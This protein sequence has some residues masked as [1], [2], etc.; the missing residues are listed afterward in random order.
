MGERTHTLLAAVLAVLLSCA[1]L[2]ALALAAA[3]ERPPDRVFLG[4]EA[5]RATA[6]DLHYYASYAYEARAEPKLLLTDRATTEPQE[7][8]VLSL[9]LTAVGVFAR[10]T[11]LSIPAVWN[12]AR[13][14]VAL[15]FFWILWYVLRLFFES[16][17]QRLLAFALVGAGGGL[18]WLAAALGAGEESFALADLRK[19]GVIGYSTFGYLYHPQAMLGQTCFLGAVFAWARWRES[20]RPR[21]L[22]AALGAAALAFPVHGPSAPVFYFA[23]F[24]APLVP[25]FSRFEAR[26]AWARLRSVALFLLPAALAA[27]YVVWARGDP[28]YRGFADT[29]AALGHLREPVFWYPVGY[30]V[31]FLLALVGLPSAAAVHPER[32]DFLLGWTLAALIAS[33]NP[34]LFAWK[35]QFA[36][37]V[38]LCILAAYGAPRAWERMTSAGPLR[39]LADRRVAAG[40]ALAVVAAV[41][42]VLLFGRTLAR[43][44]DDA[45]FAERAEIEALDFLAGRPSGNVLSRY[46]AGHLLIARTPHKAYFAHYTG[47]LDPARKER[48]VHAFFGAAM[49]RAQKARFL[50]DARIRYVYVGPRERELGG[51]DPGLGLRR[52]YSSARVEI[53][54]VR[55]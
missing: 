11:G 16:P 2:P 27:A 52:I 28:V 39:R 17:S 6:V 51:V 22:A 55:W 44:T 40:A 47:T 34:L 1:R 3:E 30:G 54:E 53:F 50:R 13:V 24:A 4:F 18:G 8:R 14:L 35:F 48:E 5:D 33:V 21:W 36:L 20:R 42:S 12:T 19:D 26:A 43:A 41:S 46:R 10:W 31:V 23:L 9:Y 15:L 45:L 38:P 49:P 25:L 37:H 7:G 29:Y 32:R